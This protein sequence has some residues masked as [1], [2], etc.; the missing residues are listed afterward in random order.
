[1][2]DFVALPLNSRVKLLMATGE[3]SD[4]AIERSH[5]SS[6]FVLE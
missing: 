4:P 6:V 1:M 3:E 2:A 5:S